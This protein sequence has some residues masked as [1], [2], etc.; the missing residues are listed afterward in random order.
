ML[1]P[2]EVNP[3]IHPWRLYEPSSTVRKLGTKPCEVNTP[4]SSRYEFVVSW[5]LAYL[6]T[7]TVSVY[8]MVSHKVS[9]TLR[10]LYWSIVIHPPELCGNKQQRQLEAKQE[11]RG[12]KYE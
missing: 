5:L 3:N 1:L 4:I 11:K 7:V 6:M 10:A 8:G 12:E 2:K 9:H